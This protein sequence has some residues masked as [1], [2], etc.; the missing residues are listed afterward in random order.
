MVEREHIGERKSCVDGSLD[1]IGCQNL[2]EKIPICFLLQ[3]TQPERKIL[4]WCVEIQ[5]K[6]TSTIVVSMLKGLRQRVVCYEYDVL[7][8][9]SDF[10]KNQLM[11]G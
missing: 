7:F 2:A 6:F 1:V 8:L 3:L 5:Q 9:M 11:I 10:K 4:C